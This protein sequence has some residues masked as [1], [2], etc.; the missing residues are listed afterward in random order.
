MS[1]KNRKP[2]VPWRYFLVATLLQDSVSENTLPKVVSPIPT[3]LPSELISRRPDVRAAQK[4]LI[5]AGF[6]ANEAGKTICPD[7]R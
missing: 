4:R 1:G 6:R 3:G 2:N 7:S 5:A